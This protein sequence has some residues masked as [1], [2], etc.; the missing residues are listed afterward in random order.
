MTNE[1]MLLE[2][3]NMMQ[4]HLKPVREQLDKVEERLDRVEERLDRTEERLGKMEELEG[5]MKHLEFMMEN[6]VLPMLKELRQ[7]Y[8]GA[9]ERYSKGADRMEIACQDV[10]ILKHVVSLHSK[11]LESLS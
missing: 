3:S 8:T 6:Q 2:M 10:E 9:Y 4:T 7:C 5:R 11:K 1:E